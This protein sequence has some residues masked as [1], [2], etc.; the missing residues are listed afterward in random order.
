M[1][2]LRKRRSLSRLLASSFPGKDFGDSA[3][4]DTLAPADASSG[5]H[6]PETYQ[7]R[8]LAE[9]WQCMASSAQRRVLDLGTVGPET[10]RFLSEHGCYLSVLDLKT[11]DPEA[12]DADE[13]LADF[14]K[15]LA[16][17]GAGEPY[18]GALCWDLL[19]YLDDR[20]TR[21]LGQWLSQH[22]QTGGAVLASINTRGGI[23]TLPARFRIV[24]ESTIWQRERGAA[25][26]RKSPLTQAKLG[27][28]WPEFRIHRSYLLRNGLQE[29]VLVRS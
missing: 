11:P 7:S 22:L 4:R 14:T 20:E 3:E 1:P 15:Q 13:R 24:D 18:G 16:N 12:D 6:A 17:A 5:E 8:A 9:W 10:L 25:T 19:N 29:F 28:L 27:R 23:R 26:E 21:I 2:S